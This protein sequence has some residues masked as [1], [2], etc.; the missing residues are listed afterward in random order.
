MTRGHSNGVAIGTFGATGLGYGYV[1]TGVVQGLIGE[2]G[3]NTYKAYKTDQATTFGEMW[4]RALNRYINSGMGDADYKTVEEWEA[5]GDPTLAI[6][7]KSQ[8]P[9]KPTTPNGSASGKI[10]TEYTY[11]TSTT[12][13]DGD[14]ISYM[15]DWGDG[16]FSSW[17]GPINSGETVSAKKTWDTKGTYQVKVVAKDTHGILSVWSDPSPITMPFSYKMPYLQLLDRLFEQFPH[18]FPVLRHLI[19]Y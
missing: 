1:G 5:F 2:I 12:D 7:E 17:V 4:S 18:M 11:T 13:P 3:L 8:P 16:T 9:E 10:G 6:G 15:F 14:K 19:G